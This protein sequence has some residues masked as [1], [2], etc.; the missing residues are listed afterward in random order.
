MRRPVSGFPSGTV[1]GVTISTAAQFA[2]DV[3]S[4][5]TASQLGPIRLAPGISRW[6]AVTFLYAAL[7]SVCL[8]A[9]L[10]FIQ[11]YTLNVNLRILPDMQG[12]ATLLL[13]VLNELVTLLLIG[14]FGALSDR[15]GRRPLYALGFLWIAVGFVVIP[16]STTFS[17]LVL[18]TMFWSVGAAAVGA[19][20]ATVLADIP[21]ERSRGALVGLTGLLQCAGILIGI[22]VLS[23]LPKHFALQGYDA[24]TAGRLTYWS[25]AALCIVSAIVCLAGLKR[26]APVVAQE[27]ESWFRLLGQGAAAAARNKRVLLGYA[28]NFVARADIVIIG[29]YFSLRVTQAGLER[30]LHAPDAIEHAGRLYGI[31]QSAALVAAAVFLLA[32][33]RFDRVTTVAAAMIFAAVGYGWVGAADPFA[34]TMYVAAIAMGLGELGA[35]LSAQLLLGREAPARLRGAVLGLAGLF[36]SL[37]VLFANLVAGPLYDAW[38]RSAPFYV[39]AACNL[40]VLAWAVWIRMTD[41]APAP[42]RE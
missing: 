22:F 5:S 10:S 20:L 31:A 18:S 33:D 24:I 4:L 32:A 9:F 25:A 40:V 14:P 41:P 1:A 34:T 6:N 7:A 16:V 19:M 2:P 12:R 17:S 29:T 36:G 30:G 23:R 37:G 3:P 27:H 15:I 39:V 26:G 38:S 11:P 8:L 42:A 13:G 28:A 35:I 21:Q